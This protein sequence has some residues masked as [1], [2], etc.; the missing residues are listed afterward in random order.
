M[1][2]KQKEIKLAL[3]VDDCSS[4]DENNVQVVDIVRIQPLNGTVYIVETKPFNNICLKNGA[5]ETPFTHNEIRF[6]LNS[7]HP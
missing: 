5:G 3:V 4:Y 2:D 1:S 6:Y 7:L